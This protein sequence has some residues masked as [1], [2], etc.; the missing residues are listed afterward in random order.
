MFNEY[1]LLKKDDYSHGSKL[2]SIDSKAMVPKYNM[3]T[4]TH[5]GYKRDTDFSHKK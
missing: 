1:V 2:K 4:G 5:H 3:D